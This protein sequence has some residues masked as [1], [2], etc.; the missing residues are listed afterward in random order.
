MLNEDHD[1]FETITFPPFP[2]PTATTSSLYGTMENLVVWIVNERR[3]LL[4][5]Y[6]TFNAEANEPGSRYKPLPAPRCGSRPVPACDTRDRWQIVAIVDQYRCFEAIRRT[7]EM[8]DA[9]YRTHEHNLNSRAALLTRDTVIDFAMQLIEQ[10]FVDP[11]TREAQVDKYMKI[12][13]ARRR[14]VDKFMRN[15]TAGA[16]L[17][18]GDD[19]DELPTDIGTTD[20]GS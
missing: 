10:A 11:E 13:A 16:E 8:W 17:E 19:T 20:Y 6:E 14:R 12:M 2:S 18:I 3:T 4:S 5:E 9:M 1:N 7:R 15:L